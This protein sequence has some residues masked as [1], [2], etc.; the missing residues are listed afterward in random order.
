MFTWLLNNANR[1]VM[2]NCFM[3]GACGPKN[4]GGE[5][6]WGW[7]I[8]KETTHFYEF[9]D[10][11]EAHFTNSNNKAEYLALETLLL[12]LVKNKLNL[13]QLKM[14]SDNRMLVM[15]MNRGHGCY[16]GHYAP[17]A[18]RCQILLKQFPC[19]KFKWIPREQNEYADMLSKKS[20]HYTRVAK[21]TYRVYKSKCTSDLYD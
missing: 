19:I 15:Q 4:P 11:G 5:M 12:Y 1:W 14:H 9:S 17:V 6:G 8:Y 16:K 20:L 10:Q 3:D 7:V 2:I 13:Q 21:K 18:K